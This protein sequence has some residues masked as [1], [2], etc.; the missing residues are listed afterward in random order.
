MTKVSIIV[1]Y[2]KED[3]I[4]QECKK[5]VKMQTYKNIEFLLISEKELGIKERKGAGFMRNRAAERAKGEI[6]FFLDADAV[7]KKNCIEELVKCFK[8]NKVDAVSCLPITPP[9]K[10]T[11]LLNYLLGL[12]Y[13]EVIRNMKEGLVDVAATTGFGIKKDVFIKCGGFIE[14]FKGG[15]GEDWYLTAEMIKRGYKIWHSNKVQIYHYTA[16]SLRGYLKKQFY[17]AWY[18]IYHYKKFN[19]VTDSYTKLYMIAQSF[20]WMFIFISPF[21]SYLLYRL[22]LPYYFH[23]ILLSLLLIFFWDL[24]QVLRFLNKIKNPKILLFLPLSFIRSFVRTVAIIKGF[25]DFYIKRKI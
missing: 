14:D 18:R 21:W 4:L 24:P 16:G 8:E 9:L 3:K 7:M 12:S 22:S 23:I 13:E 20:L 5:S 15:I 19:K 11:D 1:P 10:Q 17:H 6:L 25:W 2:Y